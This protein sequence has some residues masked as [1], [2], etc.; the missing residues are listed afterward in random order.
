VF[1]TEGVATS[2]S[3]TATAQ[4]SSAAAPAGKLFPFLPGNQAADKTGKDKKKAPGRSA[5]N[6]RQS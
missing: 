5:E 1:T 4:S 3:A 2:S 6:Q